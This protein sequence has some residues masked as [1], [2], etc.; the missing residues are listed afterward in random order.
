MP[1]ECCCLC[2]QCLLAVGVVIS[3]VVYRMATLAALYL[4]DEEIFYKNAAMVTARTAGIINLLVMYTIDLVTRLL[5]EQ[6]YTSKCPFSY[7]HFII[8]SI[9]NEA[10]YLNNASLYQQ[11][12]SHSTAALEKHIMHYVIFF[13]FSR[14][15][16]RAVC[17][18]YRFTRYAACYRAKYTIYRYTSHTV[19]KAKA[20]LVL[21]LGW[22]VQLIALVGRW[23]T[24]KILFRSFSDY[25]GL[26]IHF[27]EKQI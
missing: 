17:R 24:T 3:I 9:T 14:L 20:T 12:L 16:A 26:S 7:R 8:L 23:V 2:W 21:C 19:Y 25:V 13:T 15:R 1:V 22:N 6:C 18:I 5:S 27:E 10:L 4:Q 11:H